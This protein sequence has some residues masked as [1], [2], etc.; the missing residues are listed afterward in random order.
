MKCEK[1]YNDS[2]ELIQGWFF[3]NILIVIWNSRK[4]K[5][6]KEKKRKEAD[7][8]TQT[9]SIICRLIVSDDCQLSPF[10]E[11]IDRPR[12]PQRFIPTKVQ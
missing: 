7:A 11:N 12:A 5:K 3:I 1:D 8:N 4:K 6:K 2:H 10:Q 9:G